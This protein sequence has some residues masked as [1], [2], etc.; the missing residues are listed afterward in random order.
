FLSASRARD[1][2][3]LLPLNRP[4]PAFA[5][6]SCGSIDRLEN[7]IPTACKQSFRELYTNR[8]RILNGSFNRV[9]NELFT[10]H[11]GYQS[12]QPHPRADYCCMGRDRNLTAPL[13]PM[14]QRTF[15]ENSYSGL[16]MIQATQQRMDKKI[17]SP[18]FDAQGPL[19]NGRQTNLWRKILR[20]FMRP[21]ESPEPRCGQH[22]SVELSLS[23]FPAAGIQVPSQHDNREV[24]PGMEKL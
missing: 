11:A 14:E 9:A 6:S 15:G 17:V 22:D 4:F 21:G 13:E 19:A 16:R 23:Q 2:L 8:L 18:S 20:N 24:G 3:V 7:S 5:G 1:R 10:V 12:F